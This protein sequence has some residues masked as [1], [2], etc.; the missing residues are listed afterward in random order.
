[1]KGAIY[2]PDAD[3]I[4]AMKAAQAA[5]RKAAQKKDAAPVA[6][7]APSDEAPAPEGEGDEE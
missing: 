4:K 3:A 6:P 5:A 7:E 2:T 1:M